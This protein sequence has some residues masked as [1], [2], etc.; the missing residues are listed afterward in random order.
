M[1]G[2]S[3]LQNLD[4]H[5]GGREDCFGL[6]M[7]D[8][9]LPAA[10][11]KR[12]GRA[13]SYPNSVNP[14]RHLKH[15]DWYNHTAGK[16]ALGI[17]P[18]FAD[19]TAKWFSIDVDDYSIDH[20]KLAKSIIK[21]QLPIV[22]CRSKSGGAHLYCLIT[23]PVPA[24]D[25]VELAKKWCEKLGFNPKKTEVFPKQTK[26]DS[27][28]A[29][30]NWIII[31]YFGGE[32]AED[33]AI[34]ED[35]KKVKFED[36]DQYCISRKITPAEFNEFLKG[37]KDDK[38][39]SID[40]ILEQ[41]PPCVIKMMEERLKEGDG[42]NNA[43]S[44]LAWY[45]R[46]LDEFFDT[47]EWQEKLSQFNNEYFE[48]PLGF[49]EFAQIVKNHSGGKYVARCTVNPMAVYCDKKE[50][51][52]RKFGIGK[53]TSYYGEVSLTAA[54]KIETGSDPLWRVY[55]DGRFMTIDTETFL[56]PRSFKVA[57]L[58]NFNIVI[59]SLKQAEHDAIIAPIIQNALTIEQSDIVS[60]GGKIFDCLK[61]W[62]SVT[63]DKSY[64][65]QHVIKQG[66]P[67]ILK[68]EAVIFKL[69]DF[70]LE[71][72][73]VFREQI[74]DREIYIALKAFG[75]ISRN[76]MI[77][78]KQVNLMEFPIDGTEDWLPEIKLEGKF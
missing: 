16:S 70:V 36:F 43:A 35:G 71:Y 67:F 62:V 28:E 45:Y 31:P 37:K 24:K 10:G 66:L 9:P 13:I 52:K 75:A 57:I 38:V 30:G 23:E 61:T 59:P 50:C 11:Q 40:E 68:N 32:K 48:P 1:S 77:D 2:S 27:P 54:T 49:K 3:V 20:T 65:K 72:R 42:R 7:L 39:W 25:C 73:R 46:K 34:D 29:K 41:S 4:H 19:G 15:T 63:G 60:T 76:Y 74:N 6:Y 26:F 69:N 78:R 22:H 33:F 14:K 8:G 47:G 18:V 58:A 12:E 56:S 53:D 44:H 64:S 5:F 51:L 17:V 55:I 21:A